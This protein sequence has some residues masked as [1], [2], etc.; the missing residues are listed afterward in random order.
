MIHLHLRVSA[1]IVVLAGLMYGAAPSSIL[2][3]VFGFEVEDLELQNIFRAIM[4]LY[5]ALGV[6]WW[7]GSI[8]TQ[9][10]KGATISNI[11]FMGGLAFGRLLSTFLDGFSPQYFIGMILEF[12]M[13]FWAI[14]NFRKFD[15]INS[16]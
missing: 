6:Y 14:Y 9:F 1:V 4:G 12:I 16:R 5:I 8:K 3:V 13:M 7:Y 10:W 11:V 15:Q 2:P